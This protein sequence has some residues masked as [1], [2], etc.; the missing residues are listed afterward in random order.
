MLRRVDSIPV[1]KALWALC[2]GVIGYGCKIATTVILTTHLSLELYGDFSIAWRTLM[3]VSLMLTFGSAISARRFVTQYILMH[4]HHKKHSFTVW[5]FDLL[6]RSTLR[7]LIAYSLFWLMTNVFHIIDIHWV[8][9]YHLALF[10]VV[11]APVLSVFSITCSYI[12]SHGYGLI[13]AFMNSVVFYGA[14]L[15]V[16]GTFFALFVPENIMHLSVL[17]LC[18][19]CFLVLISSVI[20]ISIPNMDIIQSLAAPRK[21]RFYDREWLADSEAAYLNEIVF[22]MAFTI[23][24]Y[25]IE[26]FSPLENHVGIFSVCET[27]VGILGMVF[28]GLNLQ[29][30]VSLHTVDHLSK[31]AATKLQRL[32]NLYNLFK[33]LISLLFGFLSWHYRVDILHFFSIHHHEAMYLLPWMI[34]NAYMADNRFQFTYLMIRHQAHYVQTIQALSILILVIG[35]YLTVVPFGMF[36]VAAVTTVSRLFSKVA[37]TYR[38]RQLSAMRFNLLA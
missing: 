35:D 2:F 14:Q 27:W 5:A 16:I 9:K 8:E 11:L 25:M 19:V 32:L 15:L 13:S 31:Q 6:G 3:F 22:K 34:L 7:L 18:S 37:L 21:K 33:L 10:A 29:C 12:V 38:C 26:I 36:G 1:V 4:D 23:N 17:L 30:V 28:L 20:A 24:L